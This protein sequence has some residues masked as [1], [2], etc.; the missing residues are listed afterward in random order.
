[1]TKHISILCVLFSVSL[2]CGEAKLDTGGDEADT[3]T[4]AD[5]DTDTDTDT[6]TDSDS[7]MGFAEVWEA[8]LSPVCSGCHGGASPQGGLNL[9]SQEEAYSGLTA[10]YV[11]SGDADASELYQIMLGTG[12]DVMPPSGALDAEHLERVALWINDGLLE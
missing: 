4:D 2:S 3:D 6:D 7:G 8:T 10:G 5:A 11:V 1:M 9:S 12:G